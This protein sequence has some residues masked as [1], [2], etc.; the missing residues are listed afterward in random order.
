MW[1]FFWGDNAN[2]CNLVISNCKWTYLFP[3]AHDLA[4]EQKKNFGDDIACQLRLAKKKRWNVMEEKRINQEIA[5]QEYLNKLML[6][7]QER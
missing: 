5:L 1:T 6:D 2:N 3:T 4:R 7:D